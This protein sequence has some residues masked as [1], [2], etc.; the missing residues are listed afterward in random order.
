[1]DF[2]HDHQ[3]TISSV[4]CDKRFRMIPYNTFNFRFKVKS[5]VAGVGVGVVCVHCIYLFIYLRLGKEREGFT[6]FSGVQQD[7]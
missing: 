3:G 1:M 6:H 4:S 2:L 7:I 5:L